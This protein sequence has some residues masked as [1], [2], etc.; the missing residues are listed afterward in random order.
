MIVNDSAEWKRLVTLWAETEWKRPKRSAGLDESF[1]RSIIISGLVESILNCEIFWEEERGERLEGQKGKKKFRL[2]R[3]CLNVN[4]GI[5]EQPNLLLEGGG[6]ILN[7]NGACSHW[8]VWKRFLV[9]R[10]EDTCGFEACLFAYAE[11]MTQNGMTERISEKNGKAPMTAEAV[12][13]APETMEGW[14]KACL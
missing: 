10:S 2:A 1:S 4:A 8:S 14:R 7:Q 12:P 3:S 6:V 5:S 9:Q 13:W 11:S